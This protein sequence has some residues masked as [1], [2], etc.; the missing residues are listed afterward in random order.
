[1]LHTYILVIMKKRK[2][3]AKTGLFIY[4]AASCMHV[5]AFTLINNYYA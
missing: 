4:R 5:R 2:K 1:M 3:T